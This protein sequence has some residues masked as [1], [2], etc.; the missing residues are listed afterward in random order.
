MEFPFFIFLCSNEVH[1][2]LK[3]AMVYID[4]FIGFKMLLRKLI[5][6]FV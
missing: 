3:L 4:G 5:L 6:Y 2:S 1:D